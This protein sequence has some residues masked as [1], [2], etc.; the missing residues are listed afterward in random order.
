ML[1]RFV[2][3]QV[4]EIN[5][6]DRSDEHFQEQDEFDLGFEICF[7]GGVNGFGNLAHG[8]MHREVLKPVVDDEAE[9]ES[10]AADGRCPNS[11]GCG[12]RWNY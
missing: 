4:A 6:Q 8:G 1:A 10:Q 2:R 9:E 5:N 7:A 12:R 3:G 11:A